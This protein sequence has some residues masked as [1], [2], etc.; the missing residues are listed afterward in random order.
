MLVLVALLGSA[1]G[2]AAPSSATPAAGGL[3]ALEAAEKFS[4]ELPPKY[5]AGVISIIQNI[6]APSSDGRAEGWAFWIDYPDDFG[7]GWHAVF[8]NTW[9]GHVTS[10]AEHESPVD[11]GTSAVTFEAPPS[12]PIRAIAARWSASVIDSSKAV[13]I[14]HQKVSNEP[15]AK[16]WLQPYDPSRVR[17]RGVGW[18]LYADDDDGRRVA[19]MAVVDA[20]TGDVLWAN[21]PEEC[22]SRLPPRQTLGVPAPTPAVPCG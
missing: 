18:D 14:F 1:C 9:D 7:R 2:L 20:I 8:V 22:G 10:T 4:D 19:P 21:A 3:T 17:A 13:E 6:D 15:L 12:Y 16:A 11:I 5:R